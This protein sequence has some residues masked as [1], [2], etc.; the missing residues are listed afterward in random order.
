[1]NKK[2]ISKCLKIYYQ[3][4]Q[5]DSFRTVCAILHQ[6]H[7]AAAADD[8]DVLLFHNCNMTLLVRP[9]FVA[10]KFFVPLLSC[11]HHFM[12]LSNLIVVSWI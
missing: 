9:K 2:G 8:G 6:M 1:M 7:V 12:S 5:I 3:S 4:F 11:F 10:F